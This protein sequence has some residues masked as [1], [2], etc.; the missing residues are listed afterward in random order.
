MTKERLK[1]ILKYLECYADDISY[2][3]GD[4]FENLNYCTSGTPYFESDVEAEA[5]VTEV[6]NCVEKLKTEVQ[7]ETNTN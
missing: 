6:S 1:E 3:S 4:G 2:Q 5:W 7:D